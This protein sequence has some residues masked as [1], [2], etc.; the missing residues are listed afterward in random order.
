MAVSA[1]EKQKETSGDSVLRSC[2]SVPPPEGSTALSDRGVLGTIVGRRNW[3]NKEQ[4]DALKV[5]DRR[6]V[7]ETDPPSPP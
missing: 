5:L 4:A 1:E 3:R 6:V 7:E 2:E